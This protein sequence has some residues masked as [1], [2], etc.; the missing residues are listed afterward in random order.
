MITNDPSY[1]LAQQ[2]ASA[3]GIS[4]A[5][6][7]AAATQQAL[8]Q[9]GM[10]PDFSGLGISPDQQ[11]FLS[12]DVTPD[13]SAL[14][15]QN[16]TNGLSTEAQ[17]QR[18]NQQNTLLLQQQLAGRGALSSGEA[19]Y[20]LGN[21]QQNYNLAQSNAVN[22]LLSTIAGYQNQYVTAQQTAQ[23]QLQAA[24]QAAEQTQASLPQNQP[25][26]PQSFAYD[27]STGKY[28]GNGTSYTP[29]TTANGNVV[30]DDGTGTAYILNPDGS[31]GDETS[32]APQTPIP[33]GWE[34]NS[35]TAP[36]PT[37]PEYG[38]T[39]GPNAGKRESGGSIH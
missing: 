4:S 10:V 5:A 17:L 11:G 36:T 35:P 30:V 19:N 1:Q 18:Q 37:P 16:T 6:Q 33:G 31:I 14:A 20:Q 26:Q 23:Q 29:H 9:F 22:Q 2:N 3:S 8:I 24:M 32:Y 28:T 39:T 12:Q 27:A 25:T 34:Y 21:N 13:I 7:R 38:I 15:Q